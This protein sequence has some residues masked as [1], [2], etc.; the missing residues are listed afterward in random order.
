MIDGINARAIVIIAEW[1]L[2]LAVT[3][4]RCLIFWFFFAVDALSVC[5]GGLQTERAFRCSF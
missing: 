5:D 2:L 4:R 3:E 1:S